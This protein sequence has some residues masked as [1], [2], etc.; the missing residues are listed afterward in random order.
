MEDGGNCR[1]A[2][3]VKLAH[4][5]MAPLSAVQRVEHEVEQHAAMCTAVL[6]LGCDSLWTKLAIFLADAFLLVGQVKAGQAFDSASKA[7][8]DAVREPTAYEKAK[9]YMS[10]PSTADKIKAG[11]ADAYAQAKV[12]FILCHC[13]VRLDSEHILALFLPL[14]WLSGSS[15]AAELHNLH[16]PSFRMLHS[17]CA[18]KYRCMHWRL[19]KLRHT[20]WGA[21]HWL[22]MHTTALPTLH[23]R[24]LGSPPPLR[25]PRPS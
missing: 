23:T 15:S 25:R 6:S 7:A 14:S 1:H 10:G 3:A 13:A 8:Y 20:V 17:L 12:P 11:A 22:L 9:G 21:G 18:C 24:P 4:G 2:L 16:L 5:S 19:T